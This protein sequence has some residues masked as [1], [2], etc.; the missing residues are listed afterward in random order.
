MNLLSSG[1]WLTDLFIKIF[2][3]QGGKPVGTFSIGHI[4][5]ILISF[6]LPVLFYFIFR[7]RSDE[8]RMK[9]TKVLAIILPVSYCIDY[10]LQPFYNGWTMDTMGGYYIGT[11]KLPFHICTLTGAILVPFSYFNKKFMKFS[12][13]GQGAD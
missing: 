13:S 2:G 7:N 9:L 11:D 5:L 4:S 8:A 1:S 12:I 6:S 10:L 3:D